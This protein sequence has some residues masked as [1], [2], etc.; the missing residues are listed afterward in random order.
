VDTESNSAN[1]DPA[2]VTTYTEVLDEMG[3][4]MHGIM[5]LGSD[6]NWQSLVVNSVN[7]DSLGRPGFAADPFPSTLFGPR[8]GATFTYRA[9]GRSGCVI[10]GVGPQ[11]VATTDETVDRYPTCLS[12]L[13][14]NGQVLTRTQGPNELAAGKPQ[15]GAYDRSAFGHRSGAEPV[16][17]EEQHKAR[18]GAVRV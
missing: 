2:T 1:V 10:E 11:S 15:S 4:P 9:D 8:Y 14:A 7:F 18:V 6:Y 16:S 5:E 3:R 17:I 12:Y 13:Y